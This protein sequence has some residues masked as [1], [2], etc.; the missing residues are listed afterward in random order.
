[1][2]HFHMHCWI[3]TTQWPIAHSRLG[4]RHGYLGRSRAGC[5]ITTCVTMIKEKSCGRSVGYVTE[6]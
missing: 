4:H 6:H 1:M 3:V 5:R 2:H